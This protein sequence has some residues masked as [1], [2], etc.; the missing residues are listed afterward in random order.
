MCLGGYMES[1]DN[2]W[3]LSSEESDSSCSE[4]DSNSPATL[5]LENMRG[6]F[7]LVSSGPPYLQIRNNNFVLCIFIQ[8]T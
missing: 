4:K 5:G 7:I 2:K 3:I 6:V 1:L 8:F